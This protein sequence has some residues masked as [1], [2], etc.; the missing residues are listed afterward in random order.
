MKNAIQFFVL[1]TIIFSSSGAYIQKSASSHEIMAIKKLDNSLQK[2]PNSEKNEE[3][4]SNPDDTKDN[5]NPE[6]IK[7]LELT[8]TQLKGYEKFLQADK[9]YLEGKIVE[10]EKLYR[11][12]KV[13][14]E[15]ELRTD[16]K[17]KLN[18][19]NDPEKLDSVGL[20]YWKMYQESLKDEKFLSKKLIPLQLLVEQRPHFIP[21]YIHYAEVLESIGRDQEAL[22]VLQKSLNLYPNNAELLKAKIEEDEE[23][24]R[25]LE[26]A[27]SSHQFAMFNPD[28]P[29]AETFKQLAKDNLERYR[30]KIQSDLRWKAIGNVVTGGLSF[31][32]TG[33][34]FGPLSALDTIMLF[35]QGESSIGDRIA[36]SAKQKLPMINDEEIVS[37]VTE[38]GNKLAQVSGRDDLNYEFY[39]IKDKNIN[40]FALPGGK[41]FVNAGAILETNSEAEL[42]GLLAHELCHAILS[43]SFQM[44]A[45]SNL[46]SS[47]VLFIPYV[48]NAASNL[49]ALNYSRD[50]E[51]EADV[52]GTKLLAASGYAADGV[53]NLMIKIEEQEEKQSN[54]RRPA[55]WLSTHPQSKD[56]VEYLEKLIV[57]NQLNRYSYE[58]VERHWQIRLKVSQLLTEFEQEKEEKEKK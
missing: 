46:T 53:R 20:V 18:S 12:L 1:I 57:S 14:F 41:I 25:W 16:I 37:Y 3:I 42:A 55:A 39:V 36:K 50:M 38:I 35:L 28:H 6:N 44:V 58:G 8:P 48:G 47:V 2:Y 49:I 11:A 7:T 26:A 23:D 30:N 27:I 45:Q 54:N 10:A 17:E 40:A 21:G 24:Q 32:L 34:Y 22:K 56:R 9:L 13:P 31:A 4:E 33:S 15:A 29:Q 19:I 51:T 52:L 43:H 5:T